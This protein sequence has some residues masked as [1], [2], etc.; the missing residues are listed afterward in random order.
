MRSVE[1]RGQFCAPAGGDLGGNWWSQTQEP[2]CV[3]GCPLSS[4]S[5]SVCRDSTEGGRGGGGKLVPVW[6]TSSSYPREGHRKKGNQMGKELGLLRVS[7]TQLPGDVLLQ[8]MLL[9]E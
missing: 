7:S 5:D 2:E 9:P 8:R 1:E 6:V 4:S 3:W